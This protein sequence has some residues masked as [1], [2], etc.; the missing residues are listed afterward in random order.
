[1]LGRLGIALIFAMV[2]ACV[3]RVEAQAK[4]GYI[5]ADAIT[6][7]Y[8]RFQEAQKNAQRY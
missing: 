1:M 6:T 2:L 5:D 3:A 4:I 8:K 7:T